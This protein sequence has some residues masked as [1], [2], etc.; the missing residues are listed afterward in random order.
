[1]PLSARA[2]AALR[3]WPRRAWRGA[4]GAHCAVGQPKRPG[5]TGAARPLPEEGAQAHCPMR[6]K[7]HCPPSG[8]EPW[9]VERDTRSNPRRN[10][11]K[12]LDLTHL[13]SEGASRNRA[14]SRLCS[15]P[16]R[17]T[18]GEAARGAAGRPC[19][20]RCVGG[21]SHAFVAVARRQ[22]PLVPLDR[23]PIRVLG[24]QTSRAMKRCVRPWRNSARA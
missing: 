3:A 24:Q 16:E 13:V 2:A 22:Q 18:A 14:D 21:A 12:G 19:R 8:V 11:P 9:V 7:R 15:R 5:S 4:L 20:G 10:A 6:R 17:S 1:M 23:S